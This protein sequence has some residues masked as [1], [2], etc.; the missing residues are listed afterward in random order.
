MKVIFLDI[1]GVLNNSGN[2]FRRLDPENVARLNALCRQSGAR[3]VVSSSWRLWG[4]KLV[5][6]RLREEGFA[7]RIVLIGAEPHAPYE[8][9][10]L[11]KGYLAGKAERASVFVHP[12]DWYADN[13]V[14]LRTA[15]RVAQ[16][17]RHQ[18]RV[19]LDDGERVHYDRL[20]ITTGAVP[21]R[22]SAPGADEVD[23]RY[24]RTLED[25]DRLRTSFSPGARVAV[26][27]AR[28]ILFEAAPPGHG[29]ALA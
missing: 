24:L 22:L 7:G 13:Q 23:V 17:D 2:S 6:E 18:H 8:R 26:T 1:D 29:P 14:E 19:V 3:V 9:P 11:S 15:T 12:P 5:R 25:S 10:P 21:R 27:G 20:L 16:L 28:G 4:M